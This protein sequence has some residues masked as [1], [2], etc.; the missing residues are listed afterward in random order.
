ME[1]RPLPQ[2]P[3]L[4]Q[5][6]KQAKDLLKACKSAD[7]TAIRVWA[8]ERAAESES[9]AFSG[10]QLEYS[11]N[12]APWDILERVGGMYDLKYKAIGLM[13][14]PYGQVR[15]STSP[16]APKGGMLGPSFD[17]IAPAAAASAA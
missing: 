15:D 12:E 13:N 8:E 16:S 9:R 11:F 7:A 10:R 14:I 1:A 4:D 2:R 5:Y 6:K 3:S 17:Y